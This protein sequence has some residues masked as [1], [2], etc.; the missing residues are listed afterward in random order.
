MTFIIQT[1]PRV[2]VGRPRMKAL[3]KQNQIPA[4]LHRGPTQESLLL[5]LTEQVAFEKA[6]RTSNNDFYQLAV[7]AQL[8]EVRLKEVQRH[9]V[10]QKLLHADFVICTNG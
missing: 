8:Y 7:G 10:S 1:N 6:L 2:V 3:R 9:P 5:S 4:V